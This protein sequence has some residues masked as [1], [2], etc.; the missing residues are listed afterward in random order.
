MKHLACLEIPTK[1]E[2]QLAARGRQRLATVLGN[3]ETARLR[4]LDSNLDLE[5]PMAAV[6]MLAHILDQMAA[7]DAAA[8]TPMHTELTTQ[9]AADFLNV[10]RPYLIK[11]LEEDKIPFFK[12]GVHR[13]IRFQDMVQY[14]HERDIK[15]RNALDELA[16][17]AQTFGM[18]YG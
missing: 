5:L 10:S 18:G 15:S 4:L 12:V 8:L 11:L 16:E 13:R 1:Q 14:R 2:S 3:G 17:Q 7:G 9:Q 6:Q